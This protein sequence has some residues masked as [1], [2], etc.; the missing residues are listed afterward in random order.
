[1]VS[2][3]ITSQALD[4]AFTFLNNAIEGKLI[5]QVF[6]TYDGLVNIVLQF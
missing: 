4:Q 5:N 2:M 3:K 1:M 6:H